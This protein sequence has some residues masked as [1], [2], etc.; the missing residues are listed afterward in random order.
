MNYHHVQVANELI[1][2]EILPAHVVLRIAAALWG[3]E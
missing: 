1:T 2:A 3:S